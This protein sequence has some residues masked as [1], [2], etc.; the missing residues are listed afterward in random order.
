MSASANPNAH[1]YEP[2]TSKP[3]ESILGRDTAKRQNRIFTGGAI[4][5]I[6]G[7]VYYMMYKE[8]QRD[9]HRREDDA[10]RDQ[11]AAQDQRR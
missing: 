3:Y 9:R 1:K 10:R 2:R 8:D 5:A 7:L 6:G 11:R 4:L